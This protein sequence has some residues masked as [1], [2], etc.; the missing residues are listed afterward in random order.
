M[1]TI[2]KAIYKCRLCGK[3]FMGEVTG[4]ETVARDAVIG[5][6]TCGEF[7]PERCGIGLH[8]YYPH[9]CDDGSF[10]MA[11]FQGFRKEEEND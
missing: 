11:D 2:Y 10:G 3:A 4:N 8:R 6:V 7:Y 1:S 5:V 9:W